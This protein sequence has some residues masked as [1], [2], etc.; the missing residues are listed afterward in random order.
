MLEHSITYALI[1][2]NDPASTAAG[3][4]AAT[5]RARRT[6]LIA[7]D[8]MDDGALD[9]GSVVSL[10][11]STDPVLKETAWWIVVASSGMG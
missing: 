5:S 6:A 10:L 3:L 2:I 1:E 9:P 11:D 4:Q 7:L 8:Q